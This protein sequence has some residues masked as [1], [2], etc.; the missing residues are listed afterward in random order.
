M[1]IE[2]KTELVQSWGFAKLHPEGEYVRDTGIA[3]EEWTP[4][5]PDAIEIMDGRTFQPRC[6]F[7]I[8]WSVWEPN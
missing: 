2:Q 7:E 3:W 5:R 6:T 8:D 1:N 4:D